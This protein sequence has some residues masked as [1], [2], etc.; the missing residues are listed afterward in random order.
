MN[1]LVKLTASILLMILISSLADA[2]Q[3]NDNFYRAADA[4][5][6]RVQGTSRID[7]TLKGATIIFPNGSNQLN[8]SINIPCNEVYNKPLAD[9]GLS[10]ASMLFSLRLN[11]DPIE[12]QEVLTSS[13]TISTHGFLTLNNITKAVTVAYMPVASGTEENGNF[14][15][16]MAIQF[17]AAGFN[18]DDSNSNAQYVIKINNAKVNRV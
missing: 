18:L 2:Q 9:A 17:N 8:V 10:V 14:N 15:I 16:Y 11:I 5:M 3:H 4:G 6:L 7:H 12:I 1:H 13:K